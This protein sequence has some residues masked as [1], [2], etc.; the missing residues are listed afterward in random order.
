[1]EQANIINLSYLQLLQPFELVKSYFITIGRK[2][3]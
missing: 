3:G 1:M 2:E